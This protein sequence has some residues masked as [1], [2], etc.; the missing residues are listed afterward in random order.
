MNLWLVKSD[1]DDYSAV[2]LERDGQTVWTGVK[3]PTAQNH[4]RA[5]NAGAAVLVYHTGDQ[6][7]IVALAKVAV[8]PRPESA[9]GKMVVVDLAFDCWLESPVTLATIKADAFFK[10]FALVRI[11]R[12]SVMPVTEPQ[13]KRILA[14][15]GATGP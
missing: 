1:P 4:L 3:N 9:G 8:G 6:K 13:W 7:A 10:D 12:L 15:S 2:D 5:M 14:L 11:G